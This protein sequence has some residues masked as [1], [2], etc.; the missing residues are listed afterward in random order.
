MIEDYH[1]YIQLDRQARSYMYLWL[2]PQG[3][4]DVLHV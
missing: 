2:E 1:A 3:V 4:T